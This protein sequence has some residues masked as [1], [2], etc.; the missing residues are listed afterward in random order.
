M[1]RIAEPVNTEELCYYGCGLK[2]KYKN[3]S[4]NFMCEDRSPKCSELKRKNSESGKRAHKRENSSRYS[5][6]PEESKQRMNWNKGNF[7]AD[8][9]YDGK[10]SHKKSLSKKEVIGVNLVI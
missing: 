9:S 5:R 2:A 3:G 8:F 7:N 4:G 6:M 10:G 1:K